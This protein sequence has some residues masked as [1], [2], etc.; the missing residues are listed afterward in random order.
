MTQAVANHLKLR[1]KNSPARGSQRGAQLQIPL[2]QQQQQQQ[3]LVPPN[4]AQAPAVGA[5]T[6]AAPAPAPA[7]APTVIPPQSL[8]QVLAGGSLSHHEASLRELGCA[9]PEDLKNLEEA[10]LMELGMKRV[11]VKRLMRVAKAL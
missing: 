3:Q 2:V 5:S 7:L 11:E 9:E 8:S 10:D 4:Q 6:F 1:P